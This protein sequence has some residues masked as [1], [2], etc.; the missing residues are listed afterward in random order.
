MRSEDAPLPVLVPK[1]FLTSLAMKWQPL[2]THFDRRCCP[3]VSKQRIKPH[4]PRSKCR[5]YRELRTN[6]PELTEGKSVFF[7][8]VRHAAFEF[9]NLSFCGNGQ[10]I[11]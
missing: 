9:N 8:A 10:S 3:L 4:S 5:S 11:A 7:V 1:K 2:V 6:Y